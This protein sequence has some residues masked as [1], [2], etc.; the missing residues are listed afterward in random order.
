MSAAKAD[1]PNAQS[2]DERG[3]MQCGAWNTLSQ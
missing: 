2:N 3:K 1:A